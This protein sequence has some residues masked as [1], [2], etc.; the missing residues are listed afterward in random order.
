MFDEKDPIYL[1][2]AVY[3]FYVWAVMPV[4]SVKP[5]GIYPHA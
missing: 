2:C 5:L 4:M 3:K 1:L